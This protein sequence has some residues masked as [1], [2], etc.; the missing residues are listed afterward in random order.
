MASGSG[1]Q[2]GNAKGLLADWE[3]VTPNGPSLT[4]H[5]GCILGSDLYI[6]SGMETKD[7]KQ[8]SDK[9]YRYSAGSASWQE[10]R[11]TGS[12]ALSHHACVS[13]AGR[14][15]LLIGGWDG[16]S[17]TG[18]VVAF[19]SEKQQWL[20]QETSGFPGDA[21][22]SSHTATLLASGEIIIFGREGSLRMQRRH[23]NG[24]ML[25]GSVESGRFTFKEFTNAAA[26][27]SGHTSNI[28]GNKLCIVG[29]RENNLIE[30]HDRFKSGESDSQAVPSKL[31]SIVEKLTPMS[32][33]PG[34]RKNHITISGPGIIFIH[35]GDT[36]D[37]R[38]RES[39][40][41]MFLVTFKPTMQFYKLG[42]SPVR[43]SGHICCIIGDKAFL[44]GGIGGKNNSHVYN[45]T[46]CLEFK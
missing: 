31:L 26:S 14:Y 25:T 4:F 11:A 18:K 36:F 9:L 28:V 45:E 22:L 17:R 41:E 8:P 7:G 20:V 34:G 29:G 19:D 5:V 46:Y 13:L 27:R 2:R 38:S 1:T 30:I 21:G 16:K 39:V 12:P 6:H 24:Y 10:I 33:L 43:R 44:H 42:D 3:L 40:G 32:K 15:M 35:G 23:G 37:G